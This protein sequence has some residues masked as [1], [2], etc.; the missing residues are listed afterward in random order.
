MQARDQ[1]QSRVGQPLRGDVALRAD[2]AL[3]ATLRDGDMK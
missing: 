1:V 3:R 2:E